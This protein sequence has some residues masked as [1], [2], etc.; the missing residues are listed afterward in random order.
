MIAKAVKHVGHV[1]EVKLVNKDGT[2]LRAGRARVELNL[3]EPLKARQL[4][5]ISK[6]AIWLDFRYERQPHFCYSCGKIGHCAMYCKDILFTEAKLEGKEKMAYGQWLRAEVKEH[7]L[8]WK[9]FYEKPYQSK[10]EV[11]P[12]TPPSSTHLQRPALPPIQSTD[13]P[14]Q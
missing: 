8:Y 9:T 13:T 5:R 12:E 14:N 4:I 2:T 3:K 7:S 6:K 1:L 11:I 10:E